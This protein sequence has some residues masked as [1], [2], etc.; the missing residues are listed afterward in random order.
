MKSL[1]LEMAIYKWEF[2]ME[3]CIDLDFTLK[4]LNVLHILIFTC[5]R[6]LNREGKQTQRNMILNYSKN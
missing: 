2:S 5:F 1:D 4:T 6:I 3:L